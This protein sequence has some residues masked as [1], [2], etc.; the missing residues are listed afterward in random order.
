LAALY[1]QRLIFLKEGQICIDGPTLETFTAE[2]LSNIYQ[3][4]V[5]VIEHP[6]TGAPQAMFVP[7]KD[8]GQPA[9]GSGQQSGTNVYV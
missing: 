8:S 5:K 1:C 3:T 4:E 2:N 7:S 9:A 6:D